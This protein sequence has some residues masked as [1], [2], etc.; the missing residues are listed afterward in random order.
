MK[1]T[2]L[3][4]PEGLQVVADGT[5]DVVITLE[6][7]DA[8]DLAIA[9][10]SPAST[11]KLHAFLGEWLELRRRAQPMP[12]WYTKPCPKGCAPGRCNATDDPCS[13]PMPRA[14]R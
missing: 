1:A 9:T 7:C 11:E 12:D 6:I 4:L 5:H 2:E 10:L 3:E 14:K 13:L 8:D